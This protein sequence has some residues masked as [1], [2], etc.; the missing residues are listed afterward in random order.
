MRRDHALVSLRWEQRRLLRA[1]L[2]GEDVLPVRVEG[3]S[4]PFRTLPD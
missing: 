2:R 3:P 4:T 1:M